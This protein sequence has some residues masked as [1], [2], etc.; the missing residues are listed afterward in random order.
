MH[1]DDDRPL[2]AKTELA[3]PNAANVD[4]L[5][6]VYDMLVKS[7]VRDPRINKLLDD[8]ASRASAAGDEANRPN[9]CRRV[10]ERIDPS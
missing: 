10:T 9:Y 7:D 6:G 8:V 1:I 2:R 4:V 3:S 5:H